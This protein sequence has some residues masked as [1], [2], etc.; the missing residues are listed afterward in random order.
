MAQERYRQSRAAADEFDTSLMYDDI[1][2]MRD[3]EAEEEKE[4]NNKLGFAGMMA[5]VAGVSMMAVGMLA[6]GVVGLELYNLLMVL[7]PMV[8]IGALGYGFYKTLKLA[9]RQKELN[10]PALNVYR[11]TRPVAEGEVDNARTRSRRGRTRTRDASTDTSSTQTE[12]RS[13]SRSR[14]KTRSYVSQKKSLRRSRT[15]RVFTGVAG[16]LAE[17]FGI[18]SSLIR[19]ALVASLLMGFG[20]PIFVYLLLSIIIPSNYDTYFERSPRNGD[21]NRSR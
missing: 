18:S 9:F 6:K 19:F 3:I 20:M 5:L 7:L 14:R 4:Q 13:R 11:K 2:R 10:F 21:R 16:G 8:G 17:Y 15:N 12:S 1:E